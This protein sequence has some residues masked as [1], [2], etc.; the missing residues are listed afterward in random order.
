[1]LSNQ[2]LQNDPEIHC[3]FLMPP[4]T[5]SYQPSPPRPGSGLR[6]SFGSARSIMALILR[7]MSTQYGRSVGGY[8]WAV[9]E[10]LGTVFLIALAFS[11]L[12]HA[13]SLGNNF[14]F[15]YASGF[16][17]FHAYQQISLVVARAMQFSK[18]LLFYPSVTWVDAVLARFLLNALTNITTTCIIFTCIYIFVDIPVLIDI[19]PIMIGFSLMFLLGFGVGVLNCAL[20]GLFPT[21]DMVWSIVTRPLFLAS[22]ILFLYEDLP[23]QVKNLLWYNPL[24]HIV[25]IARS[26]FFPSYRPEYTS[27]PYVLAIALI[28]AALGLILMGRY[29][30]DILQNN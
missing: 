10:P 30:R 25:G 15:F 23:V 1:M 24:L 28:T 6:R 26:G 22:G 19:K 5:S 7:E 12:V 14:I 20:L 9:L 8:A 17:P 2:G 27:I 13:P 4:K 21:W 29:H 18:P 11:L 16:L 3:R